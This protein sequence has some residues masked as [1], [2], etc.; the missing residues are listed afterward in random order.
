MSDPREQEVP[1]VGFVRLQDPETGEILELDTAHKKVRQLFA[2]QGRQRAESIT[3]RLRRC[4]V[5][6]ASADALPR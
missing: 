1:A 3:E 5:D 2:N 4:D 6:A